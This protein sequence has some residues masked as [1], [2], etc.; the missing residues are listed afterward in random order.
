MLAVN[1]R[2][3]VISYFKNKTLKYQFQFIL[4]QFGRC[5]FLGLFAINIFKNVC[6]IDDSCTILAIFFKKEKV[7]Y[8]VLCRELMLPESHKYHIKPSGGHWAKIRKNVPS[9]CLRQTVQPLVHKF[10]T[11]CTIFHF[12]PTVSSGDTVATP[13]SHIKKSLCYICYKI[14]I[15]VY[16][17]ICVL[18]LLNLNSI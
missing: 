18:T 5:F 11:Y 13:T 3:K 8:D 12:H 10:V 7:F 2:E 17:V 15:Y 4:I 16:S 14:Y 6:T 1:H 9:H